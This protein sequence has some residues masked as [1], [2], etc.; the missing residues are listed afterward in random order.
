M[1]SRWIRPSRTVAALAAASLV[2]AACSS[3]PEEPQADPSQGEG[4]TLVEVSP[5]TG[6][7]LDGPLPE[8]PVM[9]VKIENTSAGAPQTGLDRADLVVGQLVE[10]GLTRLAAFYHSS[11]PSGVGHVRSLRT[12]DISLAKPVNGTIVASGGAGGVVERVKDN[13]LG[14]VVED[15]DGRGFSRDPAKSAPYDRLVD[16]EA[17]AKRATKA[18]IPGPYFAWTAEGEA[19]GAPEPTKASSATVRFSPSAE[20]QWRLSDGVWRRTNGFAAEEFAAANLVVLE[21][22]VSDAGYTD[23]A[24]NPVPETILEGSGKATVLTADGAREA[25]WSKDGIGGSITF[26]AED[27]EFTLDPGRTWI[28]MIPRGAGSVSYR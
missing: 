16:L 1:T 28:E 23:P 18:S 2:L 22:P 9:V 5:L 11:L 19:S 12:T 24:G 15:E 21:V 14:V 17:A 6:E 4:A 26:T 13:R 3:E 27:G 7:P 10:G 8:H 20:T 25:T